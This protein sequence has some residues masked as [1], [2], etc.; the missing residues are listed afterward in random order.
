MN[1]TRWQLFQRYFSFRGARLERTWI[2]QEQRFAPRDS[3]ENTFH[4]RLN[5][6]KS[7]RLAYAP[8]PA[9]RLVSGGEPG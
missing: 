4:N 7:W 2:E 5:G 8:D 3:P 1:A 9:S 6:E